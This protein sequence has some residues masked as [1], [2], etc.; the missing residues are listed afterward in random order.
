MKL[1]DYAAQDFNLLIGA[2]FDNETSLS[3]NEVRSRRYYHEFIPNSTPVYRNTLKGVL[4]QARVI[5][6]IADQF[7][8]RRLAT[9]TRYIQQRYCRLIIRFAG[10][11]NHANRADS[12]NNLQDGKLERAQMHHRSTRSTRKHEVL[13]KLKLQQLLRA[14]IY[15]TV[16]STRF[17]NFLTICRSITNRAPFNIYV[18]SHY[19]TFIFGKLF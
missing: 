12:R 15:C 10:A 11:L 13:A 7:Q 6:A 3:L 5:G 9:A 4:P 19:L 1:M 14:P 2:N 16:V 17:T 8:A 18:I